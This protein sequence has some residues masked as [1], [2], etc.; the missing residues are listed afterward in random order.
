MPEI[1]RCIFRLMILIS[2][3]VCWFCLILAD[4]HSCIELGFASERVISQSETGDQVK[5]C[6]LMADLSK[7][8]L[9]K[10]VAEK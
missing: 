9:A 2:L 5:L 10:I 4:S 7:R 1:E 3:E 6:L 8:S